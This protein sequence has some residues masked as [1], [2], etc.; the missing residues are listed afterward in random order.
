[1][2]TPIEERYINLHSKSAE[3]SAAARDIFPDGVTHDG[4]RQKPFPIYATHGIGPH[5]W[6]VDGNRIIDFWT[7][8]GSMILGHSHPDIVSVLSDQIVK[9]TH[10]SASSDV[11]IRWGQWVKE[12][13]PSAE[14]VRFHSSGTEATMMALRMARAYSGKSK[15]IKFEEHFHGWHDYAAA[16]TSGRGGIPQET[17]NTM[18]VLPANDISIVEKT[19][20]ENDDVAAIIL[21]PT[22]AHMGQYAVR[23]SFLSELRELT[24]RYEVVLIFDEVVTGFRTS[25]GGAQGYY[26]V[27]PDVTTLAKILGG[28]LPGGAVSGKADIINMIEARDDPEYNEFRRISH[29]GTFNANPLSA[30]AGTKALELIATTPVNDTADMMAK[31]LKDELNDLLTRVEVP[32]CA[33]GVASLVFLRL[34]ADHECDKE[35]C[36]LTPEQMR[37]TN[38]ADRTAQIGLAM[39]NHGVHSTTRF[40]V[41]AAH[42]EQDI[43]DTVDAVEK[44]LTEVRAQG[45]I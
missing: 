34:G 7:G 4:R 29:N 18:I 26:G 5:K 37:I 32:G 16:G 10:L 3:F 25:K 22:G 33:S 40:I 12:L 44:T 15:V 41:M 21:E 8:H 31:K 17:L 24:E 27:T 6:D 38:N 30:A 36:L 13:V 43:L 20:R 42:Q 9:G 2:V 39:L 45:L 23:P 19:L 28:G 1:M 11:E 35:V 14:R